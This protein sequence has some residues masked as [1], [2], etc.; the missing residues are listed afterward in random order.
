MKGGCSGL[1]CL[2]LATLA[3]AGC[4]IHEDPDRRPDSGYRPDA[5]GE[6]DPDG[7]SDDGGGSWEGPDT[8]ETTDPL[9]SDGFDNDRNGFADC[10]DFSCLTSVDVTVCGVPS[11][12]TLSIEDLQREPATENRPP[13][14]DLSVRPPVV[15]RVRVED[16]VVTSPVFL[17]SGHPSFFVATADATGS[18][19]NGIFV[20]ARGLD[21]GI[22]PGDRVTISGLFEER[23]GSTQIAAQ[24][25]EQT[26]VADLPEPPVV[27]TTQLGTAASAEPWTGVLVAVEDVTVVEV[28]VQ[29]AGSTGPRNDFIVEG[30]TG[31]RLR[32][33]ALML[34]DEQ[35]RMPQVGDRFDRITG[36]VHYTFNH[37][38]L[39]PRSPADLVES[40]DPCVEDPEAVECQPPGPGPRE[41]TDELC[42][43]GIDNDGN[44]F[45][46]CGDRTCLTS[47]DVTVC[48]MEPVLHTSIERLQDPDERPPYTDFFATP[49]IVTRVVLE[50]VVVL[51]PVFEI[52]G[53]PAFFVGTPGST[54]EQRQGIY[55]FA[56]DAGPEVQPGD[57][58]TVSGYF[59]Q[60]G[61]N[62]Q[63]VAHR[64]EKSDT[65]DL[66]AP[67]ELTVAE[68]GASDAA[69]W[70]ASVVTVTDAVVTRREVAS[71]GSADGPRNDFVVQGF[72][73]DTGTLLPGS[74]TV[75]AL[76][77]DDT[78][79]SMPH[80]GDT[81]QSIT[82]VLHYTA[83]L[84]RLQ[85]R[86]Q[87]ELVPGARFGGVDPCDEEP[88][89]S[90]CTARP[91]VVGEL[92]IN[93]FL[94]DPPSGTA[95]DANGDGRRDPYE[96]EFV[97]LVNVSADR[98]ELQGVSIWTRGTRTVTDPHRERF[99]F[100]EGTVLRPGQG[101]LVFGGGAPSGLF[102][103]SLV[104]H[105]RESC[106]DVNNAPCL[107]LANRGDSIRVT[108]GETVLAQLDYDE[109]SGLG[110]SGRS[111]TRAPDLTGEFVL[112][113]EAAP[114]ALF[115]PGTRSDGSLFQQ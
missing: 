49:T 98:L 79:R 6:P 80:V 15:S 29:T 88:G 3:L 114:G 28:Q 12:A 45:T 5:G 42:S 71:T 10:S 96:D 24:R 22:I 23:F 53:F 37:H 112:H 76:I 63:V 93:E 57:L 62:P 19:W 36:V 87:E 97:E 7:G 46:D 34:S 64:V 26:G 14:T 31:G 11:V 66:P 13:P 110:N 111:A 77:L 95:G 9:C 59:S 72:H 54:T 74:L 73:P 58:V 109:E 25:V 78:E 69:P 40:V 75:G 16:V 4:R 2:V 35:R 82:G 90:E 68:A 102:G 83:G 70:R 33:G 47:V 84:H 92:V 32:V 100:P 91:P 56:R 60:H 81:F 41:D 20:F 52:S 107:Q 85:P 104:F 113:T 61:G 50:D 106:V 89:L 55:I 27:T 94:A 86:S 44:G 65:A 30:R 21:L 101:V 115:S 1:V 99:S 18:E 43:D 39:Q 48:G 51:S 17:T 8:P 108:R 103:A 38:R 105:I 67:A